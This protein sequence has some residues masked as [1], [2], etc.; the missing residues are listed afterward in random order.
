MAFLFF[1]FGLADAMAKGGTKSEENESG[2]FKEPQ[3]T[4]RSVVVG[5]H[6]RE[7]H[8]FIG[9]QPLFLSFVGTLSPTVLVGHKPTVDRSATDLDQHA[10]LDRLRH[11]ACWPWHPDTHPPRAVALG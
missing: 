7:T 4:H 2:Q 6:E 9:D 8:Y 11:L 3:T 1:T 5:E 10:V